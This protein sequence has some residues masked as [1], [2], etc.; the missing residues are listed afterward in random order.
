MENLMSN[1]INCI[2]RS[3]RKID[4]LVERLSHAFR[5][6]RSTSFLFLTIF[7][8]NA[9][10]EEIDCGV[11]KYKYVNNFLAADEV[12]SLFRKDLDWKKFCNY[13]QDAGTEIKID[14]P[15]V[16]CVSV[17][18]FNFRLQRGQ[19]TEL[20]VIEWMKVGENIGWQLLGPWERFR[21]DIPFDPRVLSWDLLS[22]DMNLS[23]WQTT[24]T[25][26]HRINFDLKRQQYSQSRISASDGG[27]LNE[28]RDVNTYECK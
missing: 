10:A 26:S 1:D 18:E 23:T 5:L 9:N 4:I 7:G 24:Y 25:I 17:V 11:F 27:G 16:E 21:K 22:K 12:L 2:E 8:A 15:I 13:N 28:W 6:M 20:N 14:Y 3:E 19:K